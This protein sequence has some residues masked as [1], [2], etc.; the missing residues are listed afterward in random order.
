MK[1][2]TLAIAVAMASVPFAA[3]ADLSISGDVGVGYFKSKDDT[4]RF[5]DRGSN[6]TFGAS[7][8][9]GGITYYGNADVDFGNGGNFVGDDIRVG[10]KGGF[11]EVVLGDTDNGCDA[12]DIGGTNE[13]WETHSQGGCKGSDNHNI[14]YK[15]AIGNFSGAI[16]HNPDAESSALGVTGAMGPVGI[17]LGYETDIETKNAAGVVT[18]TDNNVV[19][20][21]TGKIGPMAVGFRANK[22]GDNDAVHGINAIYSRGAH[23][24]YGGL[25]TSDGNDSK[26]IGYKHVRGKTDFILEAADT[27]VAG[28][29]NSI[30]A[31]IRHRF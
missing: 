22:L 28:D 9:I 14:T 26:S 1:L 11:G 15:R 2:R 8:K 7:E 29:E 20:G 17:S 19:L 25:G 13:V 12:T 30:A 3:Q 10:M 24:I 27:G 4:D 23:N 18:A 21:L 5:G 6:I 31:G 16:S